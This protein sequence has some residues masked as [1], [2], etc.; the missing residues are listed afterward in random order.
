MNRSELVKRFT[1]LDSLIE[2][3]KNTLEDSEIELNAEGYYNIES[4]ED[5]ELKAQA[6]FYNI[7][8]DIQKK[9]IANIN[10][11][12]I[13]FLNSAYEF[14]NSEEKEY[15]REELIQEITRLNPGVEI[16]YQ[17]N[18]DEVIYCSKNGSD[19]KLPEGFEYNDKNGVTNKHHTSSGRY[20]NIHV[21]SMENVPSDAVVVSKSEKKETKKEEK[22][23]KKTKNETKGTLGEVV[24]CLFG[25]VDKRVNNFVAKNSII[26]NFFYKT[27]MNRYNHPWG[28]VGWRLLVS[29]PVAGLA[30][31]MAAVQPWLI[32]VGVAVAAFGAQALG[33]FAVAMVRRATKNPPSKLKPI[34]LK[35]GSYL[36]NLKNAWNKFRNPKKVTKTNNLKTNSKPVEVKGKEDSKDKVNVESLINAFNKVVSELDLNNIDLQKYDY[37]NNLYKTIENNGLLDKISK[38]IKE[39]YAQYEKKV[40]EY[41][42]LSSAFV[43]NVNKID[44]NNLNKGALDKCRYIY[45]TLKDKFGE[46][47]LKNIP[48]EVMNKFNEYEKTL[49]SKK[50]TKEEEIKKEQEIDKLKLTKLISYIMGFKLEATTQSVNE[51]EKLIQQV[52]KLNEKERKVL[53]GNEEAWDKF[54]YLMKKTK[55]Y[56]EEF[57]GLKN[58]DRLSTFI[59][60]VNTFDFK[61][62]EVK[63]D[64]N[65]LM[66]CIDIYSR[67]SND[68]K[69]LIPENVMRIYD[70]A[71]RFD[72]VFTLKAKLIMLDINKCIREN[73]YSD[74]YECCE[75]YD[76][77]I[78]NNRKGRSFEVGNDLMHK[79]KLGREEIKEFPQE[80]REKLKSAMEEREK[81]QKY[82]NATIGIKNV[83]VDG[84]VQSVLRI[85]NNNEVLDDMIIPWNSASFNENEITN[86]IVNR[87]PYMSN[88][89][90]VSYEE[91]ENLINDKEEKSK[92]SHK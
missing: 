31:G 59:N 60:L 55:E 73:D 62:D 51:C 33:K 49:T 14:F 24:S 52:F 74:I 45:N 40:N 91:V 86:S 22:T 85:V 69:A 8:V 12:D 37:C 2:K 13:E 87:H 65:Q 4:I 92:G 68:E 71:L 70:S 26:N 82:Q 63:Y 17:K 38:E 47:I 23:T 78:S 56:C 90:F 46:D 79:R 36:E 77:Y 76:R 5:S 32:P 7:A 88:I 3:V 64:R 6:D 29:A 44:I 39:R 18:H 41:K 15:S 80:L 16:K 1:L 54:K 83:V 48:S 58:N 72:Q 9:G 50:E 81:V 53:R 84:R 11:E 35:K 30:F 89:R 66:V 43:K 75:I 27:R 28:Y 67:L 10:N 25:Q 19:L 20:I 21:H 61:A 57:K 34:E 42:T